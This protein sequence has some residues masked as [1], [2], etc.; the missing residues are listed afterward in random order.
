MRTNDS[1]RLIPTLRR[2]LTT[3]AAIE[4]SNLQTK[5]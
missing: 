2:F 4:N 5:D 3:D 1:E